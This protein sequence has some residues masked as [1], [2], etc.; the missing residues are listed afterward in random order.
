M[1]TCETERP[2]AV[3]RVTRGAVEPPQQALNPGMA[4]PAADLPLV[5]QIGRYLIVGGV[6]FV[7]DFGACTRSPNSAVC[8]ISNRR[9]SRS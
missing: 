3:G 1:S 4:P 6:A 8:T 9:R 7:A 5:V 2:P